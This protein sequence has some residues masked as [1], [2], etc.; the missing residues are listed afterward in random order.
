VPDQYLDDKGV[1]IVMAWIEK[2]GNKFKVRWDTKSVEDRVKRSQ[3]FD[4]WEEADQYKK[5]I[6]Y[7]Q[8]IGVFVEVSK[9]TFGEYLDHWLKY[10]GENIAPKT[11]ESYQCEIKNHIKP[12]LGGQK[13]AKLSPL[14][15][16][17][18]YSRMRRDGCA[19]VTRTLIKQYEAQLEAGTKN[20]LPENRMKQIRANISRA[21][22]RLKKMTTDGR[23]GLSPTSINYQHRIIHKALRQAVQ[24][25]MVARNVA[26]AVQ[27]PAKADVNIKYLRREEVNRFISCIKESWYY[28]IYAT[29][30]LTGMRQGEILG[31]RWQDIDFDFGVVRVRQQLQHLSGKGY[32][33][34]APKQKSIRDIPMPLPLNAIFRNAKKVQEHLRNDIYEPKSDKSD[35]NSTI[36]TGDD[37]ETKYNEH[38]LVFC[39]TSGKPMSR[40]LITRNLKSQLEKH[41][42]E[43]TSFH[44][45]RHTFA[46]MARAAGVPMEDIQDLLGHAD[47]STTKNMYTHVEI[48]PL[49]ESIKKLTDYLEM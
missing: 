45:L 44:A 19:E 6:E 29:A 13:L 10:H 26:D 22:A 4:T 21:Q 20:R 12:N 49:R 42:F 18:F 14:D 30:I 43:K 9:M 11:L 32:I 23:G 37:K 3:S 16:Q 5:K 8:S 33:F 24:W 17:E 15:I 31:L 2:R 47:I 25:Q 46:T 7:E 48:E 27:P 28:S 39:S 36:Q 35:N 1:D 34:K 41:G 38:D 40:S